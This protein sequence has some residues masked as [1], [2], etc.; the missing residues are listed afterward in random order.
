MK[1]T[2]KIA[3]G[4]DKRQNFKTFGAD[5]TERALVALRVLANCADR[6]RYEPTDA[7]VEAIRKALETAV[8][9]TVAALKTGSKGKRAGFRL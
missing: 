2:R 4:T 5:R 6:A 9:E 1:R 7:E 3:L 8:A